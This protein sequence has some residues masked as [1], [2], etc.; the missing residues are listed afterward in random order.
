MW[1]NPERSDAHRKDPGGSEAVKRGAS[2]GG[3]QGLGAGWHPLSGLSMSWR[4]THTGLDSLRMT[5][6]PP[7]EAREAGE[8]EE[9]AGGA[10][11]PPLRRPVAGSNRTSCSRVCRHR[12]ETQEFDHEKGGRN[13]IKT[14]KGRGGRA[15]VTGHGLSAGRRGPR[16]RR[17]SRPA[18]HLRPVLE[19]NS[20]VPIGEEGDTAQVLLPGGGRREGACRG[21]RRGDRGTGRGLGGGGLLGLR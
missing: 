20:E 19:L 4:L 13:K 18:P 3:P 10:E 11:F 14:R 1:L 6:G 15:V 9:G 16:C 2:A 7:A 17:A 12:R 5:P 21:G 8:G